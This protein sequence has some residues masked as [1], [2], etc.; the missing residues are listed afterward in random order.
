[1]VIPPVFSVYMLICSINTL[2]PRRAS[3]QNFHLPNS[4]AQSVPQMPYQ[5]L[6]MLWSVF[7]HVHEHTTGIFCLSYAL[8]YTYRDGENL[9]YSLYSPYLTQE[10][11]FLRAIA[12]RKRLRAE[13]LRCNILSVRG[14]ICILCENIILLYRY[15]INHGTEVCDWIFPW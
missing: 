8:E 1:M 9:R 7:S 2:W 12:L 10:S 14:C 5:S 15:S 6:L 4:F 3:W 13:W 11:T